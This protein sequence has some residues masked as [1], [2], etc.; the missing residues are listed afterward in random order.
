MT[1]LVVGV[2]RAPG[3]N[4]V[5][6]SEASK[7]RKSLNSITVRREG[8]FRDVQQPQLGASVLIQADLGS[9]SDLVTY[10]LCEFQQNYLTSISSSVWISGY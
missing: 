4:E 7:G 8:P 10:Q 9:S 1:T 5:L 2:D 6:A 3:K